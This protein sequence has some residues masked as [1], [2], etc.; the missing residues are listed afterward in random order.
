MER[1]LLESAA[2]ALLAADAA[3][4]IVMWND[5]AAA[6]FGHSREAALQMRVADLIPQR[7]RDEY[8][9]GFNAAVRTGKP[10]VNHL[11]LFALTVSGEEFPIEVG[12]SIVPS[13]A[14][15]VALG[16]VRRVDQ[17]FQKLAKIAENER[18]L[19]DAEH[20]GRMGSFEWEVASDTISWSDELYRI[21]G[22]EPGQSPATLAAFLERVHPDD[23]DMLT[24]KLRDAVASARGWSMD[25]RIVRADTGE[26]RTLASNVRAITGAGGNVVRL[27]GTCQDVTEQRGAEEQLRHRALH[28]S[29]TGLPNRDLLL[30][31][32]EGA[33]ARSTR[34]KTLVAVL[35]LDVDNFKLVNDTIGHAAGDE[36]LRTLAA[37]LSSI[38]R[39]GDACA[40]VGGD[41]F[42]MICENV[43]REDEILSLSARVATALAAPISFD[44][45]EF[46]ATVSIG[47][48]VGGAQPQTPERLLHDADLAMYRA[49]Q[50]GKNTVEVFD[51][52]LRRHALDRIDVERQLRTGLEKGEIVPY[53][54]AIADVQTGRI[55][56]FEALARWRH[57]TRGLLLPK[58]FLQVAED[59]H[60]IGAMGSVMLQAACEQLARWRERAP[61][62]SMAVNLSLRQL[63]GGFVA[64]LAR[65]MRNAGIPPS[66][67]HVEVTESVLLDLHAS[68]GGI[69]NTMSEL[70]VCLGI[71]DFGTGYSSLLYLKRFAVR[72]LKI[73]RSFVQGLP[74][75]AE[76]LAIVETI[77][78][79]GRSL[80]L[81]TIA[82]GVETQA[83]LDTLRRLG[84]TS[85]QGYF[86]AP[87]RPAEECVLS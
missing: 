83:Q 4:R 5:A 61:H 48:A 39:A 12:V 82:E 71:D 36:I 56:G 62:L 31:R 35:F 9:K 42:V 37:R 38:C 77:V 19:R 84:C 53:Y 87:P 75:D 86:I 79:L 24:A 57:P 6:M 80:D 46:I 50:H 67:L 18:R 21:F 59:S 15:P 28:D 17:R 51:E 52:S 44:G 8:E 14:G 72:F 60:L 22:L 34:G 81:S 74:H 45:S 10:T 41:E 73:D 2:D 11:H 1:Q 49:K 30:D 85:A 20:L 43:V 66:S 16:I 58:D 64:M 76:D 29:L 55:E 13:G 63:D 7:F 23:R 65:C 3:G 54:Q 32:L 78:R 33:L 40:R 68:A 25:E 26:I 27:C 69:L 70:G 47:I